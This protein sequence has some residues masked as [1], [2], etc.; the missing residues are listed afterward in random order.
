MKKAPTWIDESYR[1]LSKDLRLGPYV[2]EI[3]PPRFRVASD[4]FSALTMTIVSQQLSGRAAETIFNR[5][6]DTAGTRPESIAAAPL[7]CLRE[8]G[9]S[10]AKASSI[11]GIAEAVVEGFSLSALKRLDDEALF[12]ELTR[13]KGVGPWT[14]EM[15]M[16]F[17]LGRPDVCS[18]GDLGLRKGLQIVYR[19]RNLPEPQECRK[20]YRPWR[21]WRTAASWYLWRIV[22]GKENDAW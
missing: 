18:S 3:G 2:R 22:E 21:P 6:V 13:F 11:K 10:N 16:M 9:L 1:H 14:V 8:A 7:S 4:L 17:C 20:L 15:F 19:K 12:K 5:L